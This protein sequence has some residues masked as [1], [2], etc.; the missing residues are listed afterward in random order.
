MTKEELAAILRSHKNWLNKNGGE[1]ANL[2]EADLLGADLR[3]ADLRGVDLHEANLRG[4][5]LRGADMTGATLPLF[6]TQREAE[7]WRG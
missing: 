7:K 1:R 6:M 4:A 5:K 2:S 3:N